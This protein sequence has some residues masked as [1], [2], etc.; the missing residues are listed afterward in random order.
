[1]LMAGARKRTP[2][3]TNELHNP[4]GHCR[5]ENYR[6]TNNHTRERFETFP[7]AV[8]E[9]TRAVLAGA[10]KNEK[11]QIVLGSAAPN[12]TGSK[13]TATERSRTQ[14]SAPRR[15]QF[16]ARGL[17]M[18]R[19]TQTTAQPPR[20]LGRESPIVGT[21]PGHIHGG[22][23]FQR[24]VVIHCFCGGTRHEISR[25]RTAQQLWKS[26]LC[27]KHESRDET[28]TLFFR[29]ILIVC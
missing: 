22:L 6:M 26:T 18:N 24:A 8:V 19:K 27:N 16:A 1:M 11:R 2:T 4:D 7:A 23:A 3:A 9:A 21:G 17:K 5:I 20:R 10:A 13:N 12:T 15:Q 14:R 28:R 29:E 25:W